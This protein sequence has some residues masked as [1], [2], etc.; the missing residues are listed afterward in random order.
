MSDIHKFIVKANCVVLGVD[1]KNSKKYVLSTKI[2][3]IIFPY[4]ILDQESIKSING[5]LVEYLHN[6]ITYVSDIELLPQLINLHSNYIDNES[7]TDL[8]S[9]YGFVIDYNPNIKDWYW[10][11][12][13]E[14][15]PVKYSNIIFEVIQKL[16]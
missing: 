8:N 16:Y 7:M 13:N 2:D 9:I 15:E 11:E 10:V 5:T 6:N 4:V 12:F 14:L 1:I 3:D